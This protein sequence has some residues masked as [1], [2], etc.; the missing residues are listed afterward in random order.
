MLGE[1]TRLQGGVWAF[2]HSCNYFPGFGETIPEGWGGR[3]DYP[4]AGGLSFGCGTARD[5]VIRL[6]PVLGFGDRER[7][8]YRQQP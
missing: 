8:I 7:G 2:E 4:L 3:A 1:S 6:N 5:A